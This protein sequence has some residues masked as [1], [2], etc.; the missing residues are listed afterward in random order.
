[1]KL[2][3]GNKGICDTCAEN[4]TDVL[5]HTKRGDEEVR[6]VVF[7]VGVDL[8]AIS[9]QIEEHKSKDHK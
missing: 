9:K 3:G 5:I 6:N 4:L 2:I 7:G 1:M 8:K